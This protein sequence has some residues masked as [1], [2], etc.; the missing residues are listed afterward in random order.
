[1]NF[2]IKRKIFPEL[3]DIFNWDKHI[4]YLD[5][6]DD[7]DPFLKEKCRR[8]F[9]TFKEIFGADY[10]KEADLRGNTFAAN[11]SNDVPWTR[12]WIVWM[13][14]CLNDLKNQSNF[15]SLLNKLKKGK[16]VSEGLSVLEAA[17][18]FHNNKLLIDFDPK[19]LANNEN[20]MPDLEVCCLDTKEKFYAEV[21][22]LDTSEQYKKNEKITDAIWYKYPGILF[23]GRLHKNLSDVHLENLLSEINIK[24]EKTSKELRFEEINHYGDIE[25]AFAPLSEKLILEEWCKQRNL[26][27]R[28]FILPKDNFNPSTRIKRKIQSKQSQLPE[29]HPNVLFLKMN[30]SP[31][32]F[33]NKGSFINEVEE[34]VYQ[35]KHLLAVVIYDQYMGSPDDSFFIKNMCFYKSKFLNRVMMENSFVIFNRFSKIPTTPLLIGKVFNSLMY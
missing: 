11:L 19:I 30:Q 10:Y 25:M 34:A 35:Y 8:S 5:Y 26:E 27:I 29:N 24:L 32:L 3:N 15:Q 14:D 17:S 31:S 7:L 22:I 28:K 1:M 21:S 18:K 6:W 9:N 23:A 12:E 4:E 2:E 20:K 33:I 16:T 13:A